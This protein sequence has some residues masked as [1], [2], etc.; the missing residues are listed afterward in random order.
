MLAQQ[1]SG[2]T[3]LTLSA[4]HR[5]SQQP[6][7][8]DDTLNETLIQALKKLIDTDFDLHPYLLEMD[9]LFEAVITTYI[10]DNQDRLA[11]INADER[12]FWATVMKLSHLFYS[13]TE[14][15]IWEEIFKISYA[16]ADKEEPTHNR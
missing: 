14:K 1:G 16:L 4:W 10:H 12:L 7:S 13:A 15:D 6:M 2:L 9:D 11:S 3:L 5:I 8:K